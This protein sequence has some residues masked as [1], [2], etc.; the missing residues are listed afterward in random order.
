[1]EYHNSLGKISITEETV[2]SVAG[3]AAS[4][5]NGLVGMSNRKVKDGL[6]GILK[7]ENWTKGI[8][9]T[10]E[11][12]IV[13]LNLYVVLAYGVKIQEVSKNLIEKVKTDVEAHTGLTVSE[14]NVFVQGIKLV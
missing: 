3:I 7:R 12:N 11:E 4:E 14:I 5:C 10:I 2:A 1:M 6:S 9:V 13:H 8:E